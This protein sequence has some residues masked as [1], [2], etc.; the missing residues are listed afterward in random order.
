LGTHRVKRFDACASGLRPL[1]CNLCD[2]GRETL[3]LLIDHEAPPRQRG[4]AVLFL[5]LVRVRKKRAGSPGSLA[6]Q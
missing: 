4:I 1:T 6:S 5:V 2:T 3:V